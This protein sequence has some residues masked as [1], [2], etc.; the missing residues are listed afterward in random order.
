MGRKGKI[1]KEVNYRT[2][3]EEEVRKNKKTDKEELYPDGPRK[4][5][6]ELEV[7]QV[8]LE[9]QN[10]ELRSTQGELEE[11]RRKYSDLYD[12]APV[13][14]FSLD[15]KGVILELNLPGAE[16][17]HARRQYLIQ[18]PFFS[19]VHRKHT[20]TFFSHIKKVIHTQSRQSCEIELLLKPRSHR[21]IQQYVQL[22]SI[23]VKDSSGNIRRLRTAVWDI[24]GRKRAEEKIALAN[25]EWESTFDAIPDIIMIIDPQYRIMR[26][27]KAA[28]ERLGIARKD[29]T[30][31]ICHKVVH[32]TDK[33]PSYCAH[34]KVISTGREKAAEFYEDHM[35]DHF[36]LS[37]TP[38]TNEEGR[39]TGVV[40]V[41][42]KITARKNME[43][44]LKAASI[45]DVLTGLL[46]RRGFVALG[47]QQCKIANRKK[48][49]ISMVYID[50]D[51]M[52]AINDRHGHKAGDSA[53]K[54]TAQVIKKT[55][56]ES[57]IMAR[58]GGDEFAVLLSEPP[59]PALE[60]VLFKHIMHSVR[61]F[62]EQNDREYDL[63]FSL[64]FASSD[65]AHPSSLE[66]LLTRADSSMYQNKRGKSDRAA[67]S[68]T[69]EVSVDTRNFERF[70]TGENC[71]AEISG[72]YKV[73][74]K[75]ISSGGIR[76]TNIHHLVTSTFRS[77][78]LSTD[79]ERIPVRAVMVW[80]KLT[81][82]GD[83]E[84]GLKFIGLSDRDR[85]SLKNIIAG[86]SF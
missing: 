63:S 23:P 26:A 45:T 19:F 31:S 66:D 27:N 2:R 39:R 47:E 43:E 24:A 65:P 67:Q 50:L 68:R 16:L 5:I 11:S 51:D 55:F 84:A 57:D 38:V 20:D 73:Q 12:F 74:V 42:H 70:E 1:N 7:H 62:N 18:K 36:A 53:L 41:F 82:T 10:E 9:M 77:M 13:G 8:E 81:G 61:S 15:E 69:K 32:G 59:E 25:K 83:Y 30:D 4:L 54:D 29:L 33:P 56:R 49:G 14:Y 34:K 52:K 22:E 3:A 85:Q 79:S 71:R 35:R 60:G 17:L 72:P 21:V 48:T 86:L 28:S 37:C 64:G 40:E 58:M 46:N 78:K 80:S 44:Q 75:N 6:H 76:L